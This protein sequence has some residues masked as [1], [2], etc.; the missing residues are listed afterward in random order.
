MS[1]SVYTIVP[2]QS[3]DFLDVAALDRMAWPDAEDV[4]IPDGEHAWRLWCEHATV[5]VARW[6]E[7]SLPNSRSVAGALL[8]FPTNHGECFL[9]KIMV[10][11]DCRGSGIGSALMRAGLART[12][13]KTF[14][15]VDPANQHAV[16]LYENFGFEIERLVPGYYRPH[17]DRYVMQY[18]PAE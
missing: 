17:E 4:F 11:P 2:A 13:T 16:K 12:T 6:S 7:S 1:D 5:L 3:E 15:T 9:H 10:H 8:M 14:L 18:T